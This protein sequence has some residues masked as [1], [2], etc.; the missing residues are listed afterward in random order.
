MLRSDPKVNVIHLLLDP[1]GVLRSRK[2]TKIG[3]E[4]HVTGEKV[5]SKVCTG[6]KS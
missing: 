3:L 1:R 6:W 5:C 2:F 4:Y